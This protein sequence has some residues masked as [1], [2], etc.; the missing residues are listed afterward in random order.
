[1]ICDL[2]TFY[3]PQITLCLY[4]KTVDIAAKLFTVYDM[5]VYIISKFLILNILNL[6]K[7]EI[8]NVNIGVGEKIF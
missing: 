1:M 4:F 2:V 5:L 7:L 6:C 8:R 3:S